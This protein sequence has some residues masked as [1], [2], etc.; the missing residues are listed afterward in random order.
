V[1][2][3]RKQG[4]AAQEPIGVNDRLNGITTF[5]QAVESGSFAL[6]AKRMEVSRSAVAKTI[7]RL[8]RRLGVRLFHR[9]TRSQSLTED[10]QAYY[11]R[12]VRAI[13]ELDAA[14]EGLGNGKREPRGRL[15][16]TMPVVFGR[17]CLMPVLLK[18]AQQFPAL[19]LEMSFTDR[20]VD[21]IEEGFDLGIRIG[22]LPDSSDVATRR[23]G[24]QHM[25][26]GAA[27]SY[28]AARGQPKTIDDLETHTCIVYGRDG[29]TSQWRIRETDGRIRVPRIQSPLCMDDLQAIADA[30]V[31]GAGLAWLPCWLL[32]RHLSKSELTL[33]MDS[34]RVVGAEINAVWPQSR[35]LSYKTRVAIDALVADIPG[36]LGLDHRK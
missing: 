36:V 22:K 20:V 27:P 29:Q 7:A 30:A 31:A 2:A 32:A 13:A 15:R 11:E 9:T 4:G 14:E 6:A 33:V 28:L 25:A 19:S 18:V 34:R 5:V 8:E 21:L 26:I 12:C 10:G 24:T 1:A 23:L 17:L 16:V 35:Y 3:F